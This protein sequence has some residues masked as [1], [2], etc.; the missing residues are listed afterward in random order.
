MKSHN[1]QLNIPLRLRK[2][3]KNGFYLFGIPDHY[4][5]PGIFEILPT[6]F[7]ETLAASIQSLKKEKVLKCLY[8]DS[9]VT[10]HRLVKEIN[11]PVFTI[12]LIPEKP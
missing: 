6:S 9:T 4:F 11:I 12:A 3:G 8:K 5:S 10:E 2:V 7:L 1:T